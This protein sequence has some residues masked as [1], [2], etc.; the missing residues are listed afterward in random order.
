MF[1]L[2]QFYQKSLPLLTIPEFNMKTHPILYFIIFLFSI[3]QIKGNS[4]TA[5][6]SGNWENASTWSTGTV[7]GEDDTVIIDGKTVTF[8][9]NSTTT[10][11]A[12]LELTN[13][14]DQNKSQLIIIN[15]GKIKVTGDLDATAE[16]ENQDVYIKIQDEGNLVV[17]GHVTFERVT[18]NYKNEKLQLHILNNGQMDVTGNFV[19]NY[20]TSGNDE[21]NPEVLLENSGN[22]FIGG[23]T[24][25]RC[26]GGKDLFF[27][28][29]GNSNI[30]I[31]GDLYMDMTNGINFWAGSQSSN[32]NFHV[33]GNLH[34]TNSGGL[35]YFAFG[36]GIES[37]ATNV[38]GNAFLNSTKSGSNVILGSN[39]STASLEI[40]GDISMSAVG[41]EDVRVYL[42][43]QGTLK[44]GGSFL[45]PTNYGTLEMCDEC[46]IE[47]NG[48]SPQSIPQ[49]NLSGSGNDSLYITNLVFN[50]TSSSPLTLS[51]DFRVQDTLYFTVGNIVSSESAMLILE[52]NAVISGASKD[53]YIE[54]PIKK[55]G[56]SNNAPFTFPVGDNKTYAPIT[57]S[58]ISDRDAEITAQYFSEPPP[59]GN[60]VSNFKGGI[61]S[62]SSQGYWSLIRNEEADGLDI[63]LHWTDADAQ[64]IYDISSLVVAGLKGNKWG[65]YGQEKSESTGGTGSGISGSITSALSEPPPFGIESLA[66]GTTSTNNKL[67]VELAKFTA[68][69]KDRSIDL[70]W[71][72]LSEIDFS[73]FVIERSADGSNFERLTSMMSVG[74]TNASTNYSYNDPSPFN[75]WNYYRL[76]MVD[77]DGSYEY[78]NIEVVKLDHEAKLEIYPNP[79]KEVIQIKGIDWGQEK[80]LLQIFNKNGKQVYT[81]WINFENGY[82]QIGTSKANVQ[83]SGTYFIRISTGTKYQVLKFIKSD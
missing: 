63:T 71:Q 21:D 35:G 28:N 65:N 16:N 32:A 43:N 29:T 20:N 5:I 77:L 18:G 31:T 12:R 36:A 64:G 49:T 79:I 69:P 73:H 54:G 52:D 47:F 56:R 50:N 61:K 37:G 70:K 15:G 1:P 30:T 9:T 6:S 81:D 53:A 23:H 67:P 11:I 58:A 22:L 19:F 38:D 25:L 66:F 62:I 75:G 48:S 39:G 78:S 7:P 57:V 68:I 72:T 34:L 80:L 45:R 76:K 60:D 42:Q 4:I 41:D 33:K 59:F 74:S 2:D 17:L 82:Y 44:L 40:K 55:L 10:T 13:A 26:N 83:E 51:G 27:T 46:I 3:N 24:F 14:N 8:G